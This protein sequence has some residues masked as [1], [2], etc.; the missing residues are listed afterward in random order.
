M[1]RGRWLLL[2]AVAGAAL[3]ALSFVNAWIVHDRE[4]RGEGYRFVQVTLSAWRSAGMPVLTV[5]AVA[6]L[7]VAVGAAASVRVPRLPRWPLLA[8]S[9]AVL[10]IVASVAV[11]IGQRGQASDVD[12]SPGLLVVPGLVLAAAMVLGALQAVSPSRRATVGLGAMGIA[13]LALAIGVRWAALHWGEGDNRFWEGGSYTLAPEDGEPVTITFEEDAYRIGEDYAGSLDWSGWTVVLHDDRACPDA[14]GTYH[15]RS[16]GESEA[17]IRFVKVV[18]TCR[19]G[20]RA[21]ILERGTW[22]RN[23]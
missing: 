9:V 7:L 4:L 3:F 10:A 15:A 11:P 22:E 16:A 5:G 13:V 12:L 6:A 19:D 14:R 8:G 21:A 20:D 17:A 1:T 2:V 23:P 18:D